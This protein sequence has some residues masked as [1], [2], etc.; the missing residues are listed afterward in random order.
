ML[1]QRILKSTPQPCQSLPKNSQSST[2]CPT[3]SSFFTQPL[4][5]AQTIST[6]VCESTAQSRSPS[7]GS[8]YQPHISTYL[9]ILRRQ[10]VRTPLRQCPSPPSSI[11]FLPSQA[12]L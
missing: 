12:H 7:N 8:V 5:R 2:V 9:M 4:T 1:R 10:W 6:L 11:L 3:I